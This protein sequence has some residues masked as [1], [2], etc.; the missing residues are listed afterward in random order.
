MLLVEEDREV[1]GESGVGLQLG[2]ELPS[3]RLSTTAGAS[4]CRCR[5]DRRGYSLREI[6]SERLADV[7]Q[8]F[9]LVTVRS[10]PGSG[11]LVA[12]VCLDSSTAGL[13]PDT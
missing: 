13:S 8:G 12:S 4:T 11:W 2:L 5:P 6:I 10:I 1:A 9:P 7:G 3:R